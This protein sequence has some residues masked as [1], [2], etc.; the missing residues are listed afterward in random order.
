MYKVD[1][2]TESAV[3]Q[4]FFVVNNEGEAH[5]A[6]IHCFIKTIHQNCNKKFCQ[7]E[8]RIKL[9]DCTKNCD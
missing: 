4:Y 2:Q 1:L 3:V 6:A 7:C 8:H 9:R 5:Y